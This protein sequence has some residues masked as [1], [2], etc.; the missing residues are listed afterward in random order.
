MQKQI[1]CTFFL[2]VLFTSV[3]AQ[4]RTEDYEI[5]LPASKTHNSLYNEIEL[6]DSRYDVTNFGVVQ[7][8]AF[9]RKA[10]V[11]ANVN[12]STQLTHVLDALIDSSA[13]GG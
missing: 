2:L 8:G 3:K 13:K 9:N 6:I 4:N 11:V 5:T 1:R 12:L 7:L 10:R